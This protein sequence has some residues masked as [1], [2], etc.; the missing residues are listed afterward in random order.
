MNRSQTLRRPHRR[1]PGFRFHIGSPAAT[2]GAMETPSRSEFLEQVAQVVLH[3]FPLVKLDRNPAEFS[4]SVNGYSMSLENLY[5][6]SAGQPQVFQTLVER[7]V[8]ELLRLAEGSPDQKASFEE[9]RD[10]I[11]PMVISAGSQDESNR[12]V[13]SQDLLEGL[14]V[15][16]AID[17]DRSIA[18]IPRKVFDTWDVAIDDLHEI[19]LKNLLVRSEKLAAHAA[20]DESGQ[21]VCVIIQT[22]DGY[23]ASRILLPGLHDHLREHLGS[24]FLAGIPNRDILICFR[25]EPATVERMSGQIAQDYQ[26][27]PHQITDRVFLVTADGIADYQPNG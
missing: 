13:V 4:L 14:R 12:L 17:R 11:M 7:W 25:D 18:Y 8:L 21:V 15:A 9:L 27:M 16:Y 23:D 26:K 19:A 2:I 1:N 22:M 5:R 6:S 10:R 24:P 3:R 20:Q